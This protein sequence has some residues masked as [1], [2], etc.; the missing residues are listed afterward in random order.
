MLDGK[1]ILTN[2]LQWDIQTGNGQSRLVEVALLSHSFPFS[3]VDWFC[4]TWPFYVKSSVQVTFSWVLMLKGGITRHRKNV[5]YNTTFFFSTLFRDYV[6][7]AK[8]KNIAL[9]WGF[10]R[11]LN[12]KVNLLSSQSAPQGTSEQGARRC[13]N[14]KLITLRGATLKMAHVIASLA[15]KENTAQ[16][17]STRIIRGNSADRIVFI[18]DK[19]RLEQAEKPKTFIDFNCVSWITLGDEDCP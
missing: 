14:A 5:S 18:C 9:L 17:V 2:A 6:R 13:A 1:R 19:Q 10:W 11:T 4:T 7:P 16:R 3:M 8:L 12:I 15:T